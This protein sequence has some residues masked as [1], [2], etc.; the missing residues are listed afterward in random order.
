MNSKP[1]E[2]VSAL[3]RRSGLAGL[4]ALGLVLSLGVPVIPIP[5]PP[6]RS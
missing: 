1:I 6:R 4:A 5:T 3:I 2:T